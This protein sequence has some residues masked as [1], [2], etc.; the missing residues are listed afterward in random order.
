VGPR[1]RRGGR[2]RP[3]DLRGRRAN[4]IGVRAAI[5]VDPDNKASVRVAHKSGFTY[6][7]DFASATD[8][9]RDGTP[10]TLSLY[11]LNL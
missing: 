3:A 6:V 8:T 9:H 7:R 1:P 5:R 4:D 2:G 10:V 11:L